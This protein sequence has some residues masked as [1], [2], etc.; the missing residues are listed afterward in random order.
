MGGGGYKGGVGIYAQCGLSTV[1]EDMITAICYQV[2]ED[3]NHDD[4][5]DDD[6]D[7]DN[8]DGGGGSVGYWW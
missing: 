6:D 4:D 2:D 7:D 5:D 3:G 1:E 8:D